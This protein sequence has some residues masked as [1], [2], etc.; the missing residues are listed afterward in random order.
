MVT[1]VGSDA[2]SFAVASSPPPETVALLVTLAA[3][4]PATSTVTVTTG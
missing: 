1:V 4:L 2:V 3:T